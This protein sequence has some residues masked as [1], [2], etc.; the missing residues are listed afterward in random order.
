MANPLQ[1]PVPELFQTDRLTLRPFSVA[2]AP[3]LHQALVESIRELRQHLWFL[4][5]VAQEPTLE[6][7]VAR[8]R[9]AQANFLL[10]ADLAYV[11]LNRDTG[12]LVG[13]MGLHRTEWSL[14]KTE[15]GYWV[16]S[17]EVGKGYASEGVAAL[18][19]WALHGLGAKRVE[20][21]ADE[22]NR[23]SRAVALRCGFRLEGVLGHTDRSPD[24]QLRNA[25]VYAKL[26]AVA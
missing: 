22:Q 2:D 18:T 4:P 16:R 19:E 14:P 17:G 25:C 9:T 13:S 21:V 12:R 20:L 24:G 5:W 7:A 8:C 26:A 23:G 1:F 15:V 3:E 11:A 6:S 10:R